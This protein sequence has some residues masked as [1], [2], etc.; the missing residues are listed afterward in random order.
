MLA[1]KCILLAH[2]FLVLPIKGNNGCDLKNSV[3]KFKDEDGF[4]WECSKYCPIIRN[5]EEQCCR[6]Y[7]CLC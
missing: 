4:E 7:Y 6:K 3:K 5:C 1:M 2:L